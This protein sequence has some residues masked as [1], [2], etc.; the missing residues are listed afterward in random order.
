MSLLQY[1]ETI[2]RQPVFMYY[3]KYHL[4]DDYAVDSAPVY[5]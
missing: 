1:A 4:R 5:Q 2:N 3:G